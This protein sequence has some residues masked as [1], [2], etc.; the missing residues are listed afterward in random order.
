MR[1]RHFE[2]NEVESR[3]PPRT[4]AS[5]QRGFL[6][7]A[8]LRYASVE[9]TKASHGMPFGIGATTVICVFKVGC[10]KVIL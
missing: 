2:R 7:F 3:N 1:P 10:S 9:M 8:S 6:H 4:K 5:S